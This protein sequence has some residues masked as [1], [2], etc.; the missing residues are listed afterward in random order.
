[1]ASARRFAQLW[2]PDVEPKRLPAGYAVNPSQDRRKAPSNRS[3]PGHARKIR[4]APECAARGGPM[5]TVLII[6]V[7]ILLLGGGGWYGRGR[8]Y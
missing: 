7:I 3:R 8:W 5:E 6:V 1:M 2:K 4:A